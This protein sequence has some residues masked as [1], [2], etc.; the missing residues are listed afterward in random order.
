MRA[1]AAMSLLSFEIAAAAPSLVAN[2][3]TDFGPLFVNALAKR[4]PKPYLA[5]LADLVANHQRPANWWG[6]SIPSGVSWKLLFDYLKSQPVAEL[7]KQTALL[8]ALEKMKWF[9]SGEPTALYALY[10]H[11]GMT[12]RAKAF[13]DAVKKSVTWN[14]DLYF[15]MADKNPTNYLQ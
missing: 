14:N 8:D 10:V 15:D 3:G 6:G 7:T 1:A 4:D 9:G 13:R 5:R 11:T 12:T 2:L